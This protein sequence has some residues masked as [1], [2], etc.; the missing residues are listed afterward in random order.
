[1]TF[2]FVGAGGEYL[3][4]LIDNH[5][6][7]PRRL[8]S[9]RARITGA[10]ISF[11]GGVGTLVGRQARSWVVGLRRDS[12]RRGRKDLPHQRNEVIQVA[13]QRGCYLLRGP[14]GDGGELRGQ[15]LNR[16]RAGRKQE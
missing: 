14:A 5:D 8:I 11:D 12:E 3:F 1:M 16:M 15:F 7:P 4:E 2:A 9:T 13:A 6:Q 10:F